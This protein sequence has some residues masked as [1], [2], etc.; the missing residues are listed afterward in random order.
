MLGFSLGTQS[1]IASQQDYPF[2]IVARSVSGKQVILAQNNGPAPICATVNLLNPVNATIDQESPV[3]VIVPP[4]KTVTIATVL[5][6]V[7]GRQYRISTNYKVS[8]GTPDAIQN[9]NPNQRGVCLM[10]LG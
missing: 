5:N 2:K 4:R 1:A 9:P 3:K 10:A 7:P 8:I 6:T